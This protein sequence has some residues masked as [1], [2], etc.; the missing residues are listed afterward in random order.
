MS[1][2]VVAVEKAFRR[3]PLD[4]LGQLP[5]QVDRILHADVKALTADRGMDVRRIA[6]Q[7]HPSLA[8]RGRLPGHVGEP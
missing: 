1:L 8:V 7:E 6:G 3:R 2:G 5:S 4:H